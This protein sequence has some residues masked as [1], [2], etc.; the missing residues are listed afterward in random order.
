MALRLTVR[1]A[2]GRPLPSELRYDFEQARVTLGRGAGAD[3]RLPHVTVS[4]QHAF[5]RLESEGYVVLDSDSTNGTRVN[6]ER[7]TPGRKKRLHDGDLIDVGVYTV[8]FEG[9]RSSAETVTAE[10]TA[11]LARRLF[12]A[13]QRGAA[14]GGPRIVVLSGSEVGK[15]VAIPEPPAPFRIGR[16]ETCQ[17]V[18]V[19]PDVSREHAELTR[20]FDGITLKNL[21]SKNGITVQGQIV[22][23]RRLRDGDE[24]VLGKTRLL[25]EEPADQPLLALAGEPDRALPPEPSPSE[26]E[27]ATLAAAAI[28]P[29]SLPPTPAPRAPEPKRG[30]DADFLIYALAAVVIAISVAG[31]FFLMNS[32]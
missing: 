8:V 30:L 7:L 18:L 26:I 4:D 5:I 15:S 14:I 20:D 22:Q 3:V 6:G 19:D 32:G 12:R 29:S 2:E 16:A 23:Q 25:F 13:S 28:A 21:E 9:A 1:A 10:R 31:I 17:L 27:T 11:E 24:L